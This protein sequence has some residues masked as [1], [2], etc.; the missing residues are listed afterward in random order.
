[1]ATQIQGAGERIIAN[2]VARVTREDS[3]RRR[4]QQPDIARQRQ[5]RQ[6]MQEEEEFMTRAMLQNE[7]LRRQQVKKTEERTLTQKVFAKLRQF[8]AVT[9]AAG[10]GTLLIWIYAAQFLG[11]M[12]FFVGYEVEQGLITGYL[13]PGEALAMLGWVV[14]AVMGILAMIMIALGFTA[15]LI[16]LNRTAIILF[17]I[18]AFAAHI[19][20]YLF[21]VPWFAIWIFV[22]IWNQ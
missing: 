6:A 15:A 9:T 7:L 1:M 18:F 21:V 3:R 20:P 19:A 5:I 17:G 8:R 12:L 11:A 14:A 2:S 4:R 16:R 22:I 13:F 10:L